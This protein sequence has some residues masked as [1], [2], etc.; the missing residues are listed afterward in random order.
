M[1]GESWPR[2]RYRQFLG[3]LAGPG[4]TGVWARSWLALHGRWRPSR[5]RFDLRSIRRLAVIRYDGLGDV[6][7]TT[8]FLRELRRSALV[9]RITLIVRPEWIELMRAFPYADEVLG[10]E[11][12]THPHFTDLRRLRDLA[13]FCRRE[14]WPR[15]F[16]AVLVPQTHFPY[17]DA[18]VIA[19]LSGAPE[20][21]G[22]RPTGE[23]DAPGP[24]RLLSRVDFAPPTGHETDALH[25]WLT[26]L[27][28]EVKETRLELAWPAAAEAVVDA[29][30]ARRTTGER[31]WA[32]LGIGA[33]HRNKM[34]PLARFIEVGRRLK[35]YGLRLLLIGGDDLVDEGRAAAAALGPDVV[36]LTGRLRLTG[37]A[38]ALAR[39][40][41]F[42]G[43]DS[44]PMHIAAAVGTPVIQV[45]G[46]P[47]DVP[48]ELPGTPL[49]IGPYCRHRRIVQPAGRGRAPAL[50]LE[51]VT[52]E[53]V[54]AAVLSLAQETGLPLDDGPG[55]SRA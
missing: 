7:A 40:A 36:D 30:A 20:R 13:G 19:L 34:W 44:G 3:W 12:A 18:R 28:G 39:C 5:G 42:V 32:A 45:V 26:A 10:F 23:P 54:W 27:G 51:E 6:V 52:V 24:W 25:A 11:R 48:P 14:L 33:S 21:L 43:N 22:R 29:L 49:R 53:E 4:V 47:V 16:E 46:W 38:A 17:F 55:A 2:R 31:P 50:F 37:T 9:A 41:L 15:E 35:A 1:S 8:A